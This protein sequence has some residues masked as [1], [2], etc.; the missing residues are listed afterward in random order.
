MPNP[1]PNGSGGKPKRSK[2]LISSL[3]CGAAVVAFGLTAVLFLHSNAAGSGNYISRD[4][5]QERLVNEHVALISNAREN[6][7]HTNDLLTKL[8]NEK[9]EYKT[10]Q[11]QLPSEEQLVARPLSLPIPLAS[12]SSTSSVAPARFKDSTLVPS[13]SAESFNASGAKDLKPIPIV[14][15]VRAPP[16]PVNVSGIGTRWPY[17]IHL[18]KAGGTT[19][20]HQARAVNGMN[21]PLRNCNLPG[22]GPRTLADGLSGDGNRKLSCE[23][24]AQYMT[25]HCIHFFA[26]ERWLDSEL[27]PDRFFYV[28]VL[29]DPIKRIESNCRYEYIQPPDALKWLTAETYLPEETRVYIGTAAVDNFYIRTLCGPDVF[30]LPYGSITRAHLETAKRRLAAFEAVLILEEYEKGIVQLERLVGWKKPAKKDAH[31]SF[32]SGDTSIK[33]SDDQRKILVEHNQLD[34]ELYDFAKVKCDLV[35]NLSRKLIPDI[36]L[37]HDTG[38]ITSHHGC[39]VTAHSCQSRTQANRFVGGCICCKNHQGGTREVQKSILG[40]GAAS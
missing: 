31:R 13:K 36:F 2:G 15:A 10:F 24:R 17:F 11:H 30:H 38:T 28:T 22:D 25:E 40:M 26:A 34:I 29:R 14:S 39:T 16:L 20:C 19:L 3:A 23:A 6:L 18:H 4:T 7:A 21:V 32:G 27:C 12:S 8:T 35:F 37:M 9:S 5:S 33:F 1:N